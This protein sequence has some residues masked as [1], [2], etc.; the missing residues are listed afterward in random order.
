[1]PQAPADTQQELIEAV[2]NPALSGP[3][4]ADELLELGVDAG[5]IQT[6]PSVYAIY[7]PNLPSERSLYERRGF[8]FATRGCGWVMNEHNYPVNEAGE[9][10]YGDCVIAC[11]KQSAH[12]KYLAQLAQRNIELRDNG[13]GKLTMEKKRPAIPNE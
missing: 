5:S 7:I 3:E 1:M 2:G 10:L 6:P 11:I 9:L 12:E 8:R 4:L 13:G